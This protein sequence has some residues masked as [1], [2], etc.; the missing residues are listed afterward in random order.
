M[1]KSKDPVSRKPELTQE[2]ASVGTELWEQKAE[3]VSKSGRVLA[4]SRKTPD[5]VL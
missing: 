3:E 1:G 4:R 2:M 5:S